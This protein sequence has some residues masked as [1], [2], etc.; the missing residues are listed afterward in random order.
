MTANFY[1]FST[2]K[3][4]FLAGLSAVKVGTRN[5]KILLVGDEMIYGAGRER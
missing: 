2:S 1:N 3:S 5:L 4:Q